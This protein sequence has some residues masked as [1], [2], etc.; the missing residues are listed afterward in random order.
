[1]D[2]HVEGLGVVSVV[3]FGVLDDAG[4]AEGHEAGL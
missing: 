1:M 4:G 3:L 2:I